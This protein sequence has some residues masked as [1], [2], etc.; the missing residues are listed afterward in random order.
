MRQKG[1]D[2]EALVREYLV[3]NHHTILAKNFYTRFGELD[4]ISQHSDRIHIIEVKS[5]K[6]PVI[7][8]GYKINKKKKI[9][10]WRCAKLFLASQ[11]LT[12]HYVQF[13][14]IV[15]TNE[16]ICHLDHIFT[17]TDIS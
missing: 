7:H 8:A 9:R 5:Y 15:V 12:N 6:T 10:M 1:H 11:R 2:A 13:D 17:E 16:T 4:I 3:K 14:L